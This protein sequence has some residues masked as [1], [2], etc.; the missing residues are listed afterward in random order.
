[1]KTVRVGCDVPE[2]VKI[3]F[4]VMVTRNGFTI[5]DVLRVAIEAYLD[6]L[7]VDFG[8]PAQMSFFLDQYNARVTAQA[9]PDAGEGE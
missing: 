3:D 2:Q 9:Q 7:Q 6:D 5:S 8:D 1:M 4:D